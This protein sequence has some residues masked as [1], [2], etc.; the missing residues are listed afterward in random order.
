MNKPL[1]VLLVEDSEADAELLLHQ[2]ARD[3]YAVTSTRVETAEGMR[4]ALSSGS[5]QIVLSDFSM[6]TF[7]APEALAVVREMALD[8]PF[9]IVSGTI[10]EEAAV[11]ALKAGAYDFL[12]KGRLAR[13]G[14]AIERELRE[15]ELRREREHAHRLLEE[16]LRQAQKMA[17]DFNNLLTA[18]LVYCELLTDQIGAD[19][20]VGRDLREVMAAAER[21]AGLTRQLLA[22]SR[23]QVLTVT[24][25]DLN[26]A[27]GRIEVMLKRL[28][29]E[30]ITIRTSLA[31]GLPA[32]MADATQLDQVLLNLALNARDA[33]PEGWA[34][35]PR[36]KH[37]SLSPSS[38]PRS[39]AKAQALVWRPCMAS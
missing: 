34:Y 32:V 7:S 27:V 3:G 26:Q 11:N 21:A 9:I 19:K 14:P 8:L 31:D 29:G 38:Q 28:L 12:V 30:Q 33:M 36:F 18:I 37:K 2:L 16:R 24:A 39:R 22:F 5:W 10:G 15:I 4:A 6:P 20:P 25:L 13:L 1:R 35:L 17:A 23:K